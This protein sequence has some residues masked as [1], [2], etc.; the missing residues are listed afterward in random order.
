[1]P[2]AAGGHRAGHVVA[3]ARQRGAEAAVVVVPRLA[4]RLTEQGAGLPLGPPAWGDTW[5]ALPAGLGGTLVDVLTGTRLGAQQRDGRA[6]L[7]V[8]EVLSAL[9]V[10]LL[11]G[12][13]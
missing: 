13:A 4:W 10:A 1:M 7:D 5:M 8:A 12:E 3:F 6:A 11:V 2:L 9:P